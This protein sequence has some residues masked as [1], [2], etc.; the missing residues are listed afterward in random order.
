MFKAIGI[1]SQG[2]KTRT[3][4]GDS[5]Y[6]G[7]QVR[8]RPTSSGENE[9]LI[10]NGSLTEYERRDPTYG[11][12][13]QEYIMAANKTMAYANS[14]P[15]GFSS[16]YKGVAAIST[17]KPE[18]IL[19]QKQ[20]DAFV[21]A[22]SDKAKPKAKPNAEAESEAESESDVYELE[23][24]P[25]GSGT[26]TLY[27]HVAKGIPKQ[28]K[29]LMMGEPFAIPFPS[30]PNSKQNPVSKLIFLR[31][32]D[33]NT[34]QFVLKHDA[35]SYCAM[36][37]YDKENQWSPSRENEFNYE[38]PSITKQLHILKKGAKEGL[39][40][41]ILP[42]IDK[43]TSYA[44]DCEKGRM[45]EGSSYYEDPVRSAHVPGD[46]KPMILGLFPKVLPDKIDPALQDKMDAT[47]A[48]TLLKLNNDRLA[49]ATTIIAAQPTS[50]L[51]PTKKE[52]LNALIEN[53]NRQLSE[54]SSNIADL[55]RLDKEIILFVRR[56][57]TELLL[58]AQKAATG[59]DA[60]T[61]IMSRVTPMGPPPSAST[62]DGL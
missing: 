26:M 48:R 57:I 59:V 61:S 60:L 39:D 9:Y 43:I 28:S 3:E 37:R 25:F 4:K 47:E 52:A 49:Q 11:A 24:G 12:K 7:I 50:V 2:W 27:F 19:T 40:L 62:A 31:N 15:L 45:N 14:Q 23:N 54:N 42:M 53:F 30:D 18:I 5:T 46:I 22:V 16:P 56:D 34:V 55:N 29:K 13:M 51:S 35:M 21:A 44:N 6:D 8:V 1:Y 17:A 32:R 10:G 41:Q 58:Q 20:F 33:G 36:A 38:V